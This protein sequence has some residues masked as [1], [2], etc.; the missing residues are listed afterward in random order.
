MQQTLAQM[1]KHSLP[2]EEPGPTCILNA[3]ESL[4]PLDLCMCC[5]LCPEPM[6]PQCICSS[7]QVLFIHQDSAR[8]LQGVSLNIPL[9]KVI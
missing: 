7:I 1:E 8:S 5:S 9:R 2:N 4:M 3:P 6:P